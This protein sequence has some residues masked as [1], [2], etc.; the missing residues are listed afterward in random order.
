MKQDEDVRRDAFMNSLGLKVIRLLAK[1][2]FQNMEGVI[3][4][5]KRPP[6]PNGT[7]PEEGNE[8]P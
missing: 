4:A 2:V 6:R 3:K 8:E 5:P 7:P 1:D